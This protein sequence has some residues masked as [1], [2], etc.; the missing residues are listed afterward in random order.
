MSMSCK[1]STMH[2]KHIK[3]IKENLQWHIDEAVITEPSMN[4]LIF[5]LMV[6]YL[7]QFDRWQLTKSG[8]LHVKY[9]MVEIKNNLHSMK[10]E[11]T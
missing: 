6:Y 5:S 3:T 10:K 1:Q 7:Y 2:G 9:I 4:I 8:L 11:T